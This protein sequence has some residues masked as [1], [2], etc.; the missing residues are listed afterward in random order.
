MIFSIFR[1]FGMLV[2]IRV[3]INGVTFRSAA[4]IFSAP[5]RIFRNPSVRRWVR[6]A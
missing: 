5:P 3:S 6:P 2:L 4:E 1:I